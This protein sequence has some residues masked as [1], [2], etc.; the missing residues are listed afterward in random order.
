MSKYFS[1][2][3]DLTK[4]QLKNLIN[5]IQSK[6]PTVLHLSKHSF[7]NGNTTLPLT[8]TDS[9]HIIKNKGFNYKLSKN[10]L[11]LF[12]LEEKEGGFLPLIPLILGGISALGALAGGASSIA[13]TVID[14]KHK[15]EE[16]KE[17]ERHNKEIESS[18]D[19][20]GIFLNQRS[21]SSA[22]NGGCLKAA[23]NKSKLS[24]IGKKS[25]RNILKNLSEHYK[26]EVKEGGGIYLNP[27]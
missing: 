13:K 25:L 21:G 20:G 4:N 6:E 2:S 26:I 12:T 23:I 17:Q 7:Q 5:A 16:L 19:G 18:V 14:N 15:Q 3:F 9:Q 10:K 1:H 11:K 24:D 8:K 27:Y 22:D